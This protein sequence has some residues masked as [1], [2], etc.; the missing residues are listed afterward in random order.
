MLPLLLLPLFCRHAI[1]FFFLRYMLPPLF[2]AIAAAVMLIELLYY[3][4]FQHTPRFRFSR[5]FRFLHSI[6]PDVIIRHV[7]LL[8]HD[9]YHFLRQL[10]F[11]FAADIYL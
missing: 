1:F 9:Y 4:Y 3:Y 11:A 5:Y 8:R 6:M 10:I 7:T 2:Y